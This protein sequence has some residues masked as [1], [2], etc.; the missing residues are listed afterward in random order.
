[1]KHRVKKHRLSRNSSHRMSLICN[2][3][4]SIIEHGR[5]QTTLAKARALRPFIEKLITKARV[6]D[7]LSVRR[8]LLSRIKNEA[9]VTKLINEVA[10]R[11]TDRPGG[12][13]RIV[14]TGY[15]VGDAAPMAIIEFV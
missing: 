14:K 10:R 15:R 9:A 5:L 3:S 13:C 8:L 6:P 7:S 2:L 12:Y 4:V 11:Y 1:M